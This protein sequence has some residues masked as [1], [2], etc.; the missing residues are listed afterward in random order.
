MGLYSECEGPEY[1]LQCP[2]D[3]IEVCCIVICVY[4]VGIYEYW[5]KAKQKLKSLLMIIS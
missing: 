5:N 3:R 4:I 1:G 2:F